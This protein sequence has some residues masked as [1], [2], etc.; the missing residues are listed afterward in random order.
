MYN[1][2][3]FTLYKY[4][5]KSGVRIARIEASLIVALALIIH[6]LCIYSIIKVLS[7]NFHQ[8]ILNDTIPKGRGLGFFTFFLFCVAVYFWYNKSRLNKLLAKRKPIPEHV[9]N[10]WDI[11]YV[12][13]LLVIPIIPMAIINWKG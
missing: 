1:F 10:G 2:I 11:L 7:P 3:F 4:N 12:V 13:L 9:T 8:T 5:L 6:I